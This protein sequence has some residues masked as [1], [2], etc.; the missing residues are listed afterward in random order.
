MG[1][2]PTL[3]GP[4]PRRVHNGHIFRQECPNQFKIGRPLSTTTSTARPT[5]A[6]K[7]FQP[8]R[9]QC[10]LLDVGMKTVPKEMSSRVNHSI[11]SILQSSS[12]RN[13]GDRFIRTESNGPVSQLTLQTCGKSLCFSVL[14]F[15][16][17]Y[18]YGRVGS[19]VI[20]V[21][22]LIALMKDQVT[23]LNSK[24]V[25]AAYI[26]S[27]T[28]DRA[29][30]EAIL[31]GEVQ[32]VFIGPES[33]LQNRT[34]REM[35]RTPVYKS[36][37]VAFVVDEVHCVPK[38]GD[39]FRQEFRNLGAQEFTEPVG[40]PNLAMFRL[41]DMDTGVTRKSVRDSIV[42]SFGTSHAPLRVVIC[43]IAFGMGI[44]CVDIPKQG[45]GT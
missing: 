7:A 42:T 39:F 22:P 30:C 43:T 26:S 12:S 37:L 16:F 32:I 31:R 6:F 11:D 20:V 8:T 2:V 45:N 38:W 14:P 34:W 41:V 10:I 19:I 5:A 29:Q 36:N 44:D 1:G 23:A 25:S 3:Q 9:K 33:L 15:A 35:L 18:L 13:I 27:E 4:I 40:A 28:D 21:S 17:D 24:G